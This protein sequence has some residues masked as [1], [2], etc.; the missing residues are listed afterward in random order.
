VKR[1]PF[2]VLV[3]AGLAVVACGKKEQ[4][5]EQGMQLLCG[6]T[7]S[8]PSTMSRSEKANAIAKTADQ[9]VTNKE[10]RDLAGSLAALEGDQKLKVLRDAAA[11]AKID[12]CGL[13]E[14]WVESPMT[15]SLRIICEAP[16]K[17]PAGA[18]S[19]GRAQEL[20]DYIQKNVTDPDAIKL[21]Q[22]LATELPE[23]RGPH[24]ASVARANGIEY[25]PLAEM[26]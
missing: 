26:K 20:A 13:L 10:V 8:L 4:T 16:D 22:E 18:D 24:L 17:V 9:K 19:S 3:V 14:L 2:S 6:V 21:M 1:A 15:K 23:T 11:R 25:C 7:A 12:H 5:F